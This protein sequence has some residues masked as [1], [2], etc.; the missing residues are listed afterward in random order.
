MIF[1]PVDLLSFEILLDFVSG[2][3]IFFAAKLIIFHRTIV[4]LQAQLSLA[5]LFFKHQ[6][7]LSLFKD[8]TPRMTQSSKV[9]NQL[10]TINVLMQ[11]FVRNLHF[12]ESLKR[13]F[14]YP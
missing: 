6:L 1:S 10:F 4:C 2:S 11:F 3:S 13:C 9:E 5:I 12:D 8:C 14:E 7:L